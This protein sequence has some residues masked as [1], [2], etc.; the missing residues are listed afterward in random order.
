MEIAVARG[1]GAIETELAHVRVVCE[2]KVDTI[3]AA[4]IARARQDV[5]SCPE[6][7]EEGNCDEVSRAGEV[8]LFILLYILNGDREL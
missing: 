1:R 4:W 5:C 8:A 3:R 2:Q 7:E 6:C